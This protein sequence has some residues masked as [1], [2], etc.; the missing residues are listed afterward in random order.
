MVTSYIRLVTLR[1]TPTL[2]EQS[3]EVKTHLDDILTCNMGDI[4]RVVNQGVKDTIICYKYKTNCKG[5]PPASIENGRHSAVSLAVI[6]IG[7]ALR[8]TT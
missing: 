5:I 4:Q 3:Q 2:P 8:K 1:Y 7:P 6:P